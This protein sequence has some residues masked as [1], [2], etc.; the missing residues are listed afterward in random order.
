MR[1]RSDA[2]IA[3]LAVVPLAVA[4]LTVGCLP[5]RQDAAQQTVRFDVEARVLQPCTSMGGCAYAIEMVTADATYL[6]ALIQTPGGLM[7]KVGLPAAL[8]PGTATVTLTSWA[9]S[10]A[11]VN[12][13]RERLAVDA[14]CSA[15]VRADPGID[16]VGVHVTFVAG[17]C[18][19]ELSFGIS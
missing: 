7:P 2:R 14:E 17:S 15:D 16:S 5:A 8:R 1:I 13:K 4:A 19:I 12:G 9:L 3:A 10:D 18:S 11:V 6:A